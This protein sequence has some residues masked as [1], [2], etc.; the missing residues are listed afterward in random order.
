MQVGLRD[1]GE[2]LGVSVDTLKRRIKTGKLPEAIRPDG[3]K[4]PWQVPRD[5]LGAIAEREGWI[6]DLR[7]GAEDPGVSEF[8]EQLLGLRTELT[9]AVA[10]RRVAEHTVEVQ[11][12]QIQ[13]GERRVEH[14]ER[15]IEQQ[16]AENTRVA[17]DLREAQLRLSVSEAIAAERADRI[18][19]LR[20]VAEA[21]WVRADDELGRLRDSD[22][23][24]RD[25]LE[26][27]YAAMGWWSRRR[28]VKIRKS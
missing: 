18:D 28:L 26:T 5:Q 1:A 2:I 13:K 27:S 25:D 8:L 22:A 6:I 21:E 4:G 3:D 20:N 9:E 12:A 24:L 11:A 19:E 17:H 15:T 14:L 16:H 10:G 7:D 23:K